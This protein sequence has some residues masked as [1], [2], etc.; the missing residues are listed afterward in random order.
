MKT[1]RQAFIFVL[2]FL[3]RG[4]A[5]L[6]ALAL[7][8]M[9]I[10]NIKSAAPKLANKERYNELTDYVSVSISPDV[11]MSDSG[12]R[13]L[14]KEITA[15]F[16]ATNESHG[17][18]FGLNSQLQISNGEFSDVL[19]KSDLQFTDYSIEVNNNYLKKNPAFDLNGNAVSVKEN[20]LEYTILVPE[21]HKDKEAEI[22]AHFSEELTFLYYYADDLEKFGIDKAHVT[23]HPAVPINIVYI[24]NGQKFFM[25]DMK[26]QKQIKEYIENPLVIVITTT[27]VSS[28]Q[29]AHYITSQKFKVDVSNG[30]EQLNADLESTGLAKSVYRIVNSHNDFKDFFEKTAIAIAIQIVS[31]IILMTISI[32]LGQLTAKKASRKQ[33]LWL[34][35]DW[36]VIVAPL[37]IW[38]NLNLLDYTFVVV[39]VAIIDV[40]YLLRR[41]YKTPAVPAGSIE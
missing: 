26:Y 2:S 32:L 5:L 22:V 33:A 25:Y 14:D 17:L 18:L 30:R 24:K 28:S 15:F 35:A 21:E 7:C 19:S 6:A 16:R 27:N 34:L 3:L 38:S 31:V 41:L 12:Q 36:V 9:A 11:D 37:L 40:F 39:V 1:P 13:Q 29:T 4:A 23:K 10:N 8:M 20:A